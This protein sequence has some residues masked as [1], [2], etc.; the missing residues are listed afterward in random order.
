MNY[1]LYLYNSFADSDPQL[2]YVPTTSPLRPTLKPIADLSLA[3]RKINFV[4]VIKTVSPPQKSRGP[5]FFT[6]VVL[7]DE[8]SQVEGMP[9]TFF[10]PQESQLPEMAAPG[11]V[12]YLCNM[13]LSEYEGRLQARGHERSKGVCFKKQSDGRIIS[14]RP[15]LEVPVVV[16]Q[17]VKALLE[18]VVSAQ[19]LLE[20]LE[21]SALDNPASA[22]S[23]VCHSPS[24][25]SFKPPTYLTLIF[26][27]TWEISSLISIL[28]ADRV[29]SCFRTR[30]KV[31]QVLQPLEECCQLRCPQCK[32]KFSSSQK[33]GTVCTHCKKEGKADASK[34]R[35]MFCLSLLVQDNSTSLEV[36]L[37]DTDADEFFRDLSP[38]NFVED[39]SIQ[40]ELWKILSALVGGTDPFLLSTSNDFHPWIDCCIQTYPSHKGTQ[41]RIVDTWFIK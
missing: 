36:H 33:A 40:Q 24:R 31:L 10:N 1:A 20:D 17:R 12:A 7:I 27:P 39:A 4:G 29:P 14:T 30:V 2:L 3:D 15:N 21:D 19:P 41:F 9:F 38:S 28:L 6:S 16:K 11:S 18:W 13:E 32:Y 35:Y 22:T 37:T 25:P 8:T 34:L 23:I 5:D 26:H